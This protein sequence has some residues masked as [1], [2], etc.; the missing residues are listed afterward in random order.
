MKILAIIT[1]M[2]VGILV[3]LVLTQGV[4]MYIIPTPFEASLMLRLFVNM[5]AA[6]YVAIIVAN[7]VIEWIIRH[8]H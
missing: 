1:G 8:I 7:K 6:M 5:I 3:Y 4:S 2:L